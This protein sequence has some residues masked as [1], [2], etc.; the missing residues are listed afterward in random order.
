[1]RS[2]SWLS[3]AALVLLPATPASA[4]L[5]RPGQTVNLL[6]DNVPMPTG[7]LLE[8][9]STD[10]TIDYGPLTVPFNDSAKLQGTL[11]SAVYRGRSGRLT[12][13]YDIDLDNNSNT[14]SGGAAEASELRIGS[15]KSFKTTVFGTM[16]FEQVIRGS[17]SRDG[18]Q[19]WLTSTAPGLGGPPRMVIRTD[20]TAYDANGHASFLAADEIPTLSGSRMASGMAN[21]GG[22]FRPITITA[23][24]PPPPTAGGTG[25][26]TGGD[27]GTG[28]TGVGS[29]P[30]PS[31]VP[32]PPAAYSGLGVLVAMGLIALTRR[33]WMTG[34]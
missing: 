30:T 5:V 19:V 9:K 12:F 34:R 8:R 22:M 16:D 21:F 2:F 24:P 26:S 14:L 23:P 15:F 4:G 11:F 13:V 27:T 3:I 7:T 32:L 28:G 1:M 6:A 20:A 18:S 29:N 10:F 31:P 17:R 33:G 25:S